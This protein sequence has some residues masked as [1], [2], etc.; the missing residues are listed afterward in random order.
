MQPPETV[1]KT[2]HP[3]AAQTQTHIALVR[4]LVRWSANSAPIR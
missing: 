3:T 2:P 4:G 1:A